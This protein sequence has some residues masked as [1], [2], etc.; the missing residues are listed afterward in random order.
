MEMG[1]GIRLATA[2][3]A[4][5][6]AFIPTV[7]AQVAD[8]RVP[9]SVFVAVPFNVDVTMLCP[10]P[11]EAPPPQYCGGGTFGF[12]ELSEGSASGPIDPVFISSRVVL[13][14]GPFS[15]HKPGR[16]FIVVVAEETLEQ[17]GGI[18]FDVV[19]P[20]GPV[21]RLR[22]R[23]TPSRVPLEDLR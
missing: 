16:Q 13:T 6:A 15:F 20:K 2:L 21:E 3:A 9:A 18:A 17:L 10:P 14:Y 8:V 23:P 19:P 5:V 4:L 22:Y 11:D 1:G 7:S 12:F